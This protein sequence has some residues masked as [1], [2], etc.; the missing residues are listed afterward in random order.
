MYNR[1]NEILNHGF[2]GKWFL[3]SGSLLGVVR[4][5]K[6]LKSD[7]GIDISVIVND[8][9]DPEI[10]NT[11]RRLENLGFVVSR[12]K[13]GDVVYKYCIA[14]K[15]S[16]RFPYAI[17]LHLFKRLNDEYICPQVSL[18]SQKTLIANLTTSLKKGGMPK[19]K[20][21]IKGLFIKVYSY[22]Y[23][24]V[25]KYFGAPMRMRKRALEGTGTPYLWFIPVF[26]FNGVESGIVEN[27]NVLKAPESYLEFRYG[28]WRIPVSDWVTLRDDGGIRKSSV[29]EIDKLI[30][31]VNK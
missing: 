13:W 22:I 29:E 2:S 9:S 3:D 30:L 6:F 11:V 10:E 1:I 12:Y 26:L 5:G 18:M 4:D 14:P 27:M 31:K 17:D 7:R 16:S 19:E 25:F 21:G 28:K 20:K 24:D 15:N 23:R 8:Y